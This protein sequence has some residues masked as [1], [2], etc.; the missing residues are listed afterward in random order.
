MLR[1]WFMPMRISVWPLAKINSCLSN[2]TLA[3][4]QQSILDSGIRLNQW[5]LERS[6]AA[7]P[8]NAFKRELISS[9]FSQ[10]Q[11]SVILM[12]NVDYLA[13]HCHQ[14]KE[15]VADVAPRAFHQVREKDFFSLGPRNTVMGELD[16]AY[17]DSLFPDICLEQPEL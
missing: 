13:S 14:I 1:D 16:P 10:R 5:T 8:F 3:L 12:S 17:Q 9:I 15:A 11:S 6:Q 7:Q 2:L 4:D